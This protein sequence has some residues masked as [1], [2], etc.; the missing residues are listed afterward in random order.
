M[1]HTIH[2]HDDYLENQD[3]WRSKGFL[4]LEVTHRRARY[5]LSFVDL[6]N[7]EMGLDERRGGLV[8]FAESGMVAVR[9]LTKDNISTAIDR[10]VEQGYFDTLAPIGTS[11]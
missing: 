4:N 9:E 6:A 10:L 3:I 2:F 1:T 11:T 7:I 8:Y 5:R